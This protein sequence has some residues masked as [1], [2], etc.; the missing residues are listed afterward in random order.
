MGLKGGNSALERQGLR[1]HKTD[2]AIHPEE[3][4]E[5]YIT[6][7]GILRI[8]LTAVGVSLR[9]RLNIAELGR[10]RVSKSSPNVALDLALP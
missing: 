4:F 7:V 5:A 3:F 2:L 1:R 6:S 9:A 8:D 10:F